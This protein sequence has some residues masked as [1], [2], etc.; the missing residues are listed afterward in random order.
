M[1]TGSLYGST[2]ESTGLYGIGAASGGTYFEWFIFYDS[3]TAPATPTGGSWSFTTNTGTAPT[4]WLTSP[5]ASPVNQVWVSLAIVD[6]RSTSSL[7]WTTPGLMSSF[8]NSVANYLTFVATSAPAYSAG[9]LWYDTNQKSF[10]YYNDVTNNVVHIGQETQLKV[11]NNTG[12]TITRGSPVYI[13]STS[14]GFNYP[15]VALAKADNQ[16]SGS[17]IGL[18]N[19]D[20]PT[21]TA[22]YITTAGLITGNTGA[23]TVGDTLYVSPYS[24]GQLMNTVPPTGYAVKIGIVA[25]SNTSNGTIYVSQTNAYVTAAQIVGTVSI[26]NGG[27]GATTAS[28]ARTALG[29][30]TIATQDASNV[31][32][33]GGSISL[34]TALPIA[35]GGT[36]ATTAAAART[37]LSVVGVT[38]TQ[39]L[40]NKTISGASNTLTN[41]GNASL[42]NSSV[43][44]NGSAIAL[45][46]SATITAAT[47]NNLV[48]G[49]QLSANASFNGSQQVNVNLL[50]VSNAGT[51]GTSNVV[52]VFTLNSYGQI[53]NVSPQT[54]TVDTTDISGTIGIGQGGTG[55]NNVTN[56]RVNLLPNYTGNAGKLLALNAGATDLEWKAV[57]G[58]GTVTSIDVSGGTTGLTTYGG[59]ITAAGTVTLAGTLNVANGG[60]GATTAAAA[61]TNLGATTVGGNLFTLTNPSAITFPQFNADNTVSA[62]TASAFRTAIGAGTSSATGTV[63]SVAATVPTFLSI[64]G[65]PITTSGTLAISLSGTALPTTSG[66]TG[67]T[68]F[69]ANGVVYA[70]STSALAT[71]S[72]LTYNGTVFGISYSDTAFAGGFVLK[73]TA[74]TGAAWARM[75]L[76]SGANSTFAIY[77]Q[78]DGTATLNATGANSITFSQNGSEGM[79]LTSTGLLINTTSN[80]NSAKLNVNGLAV[81]TDGT[82]SQYMGLCSGG[83]AFVGTLTNHPFAV[84]INGSEKAR[85]DTAG[86]LGLGVTPSAWSGYKVMQAG[87]ASF[88]GGSSGAY[89]IQ[90]NAYTDSAGA[91]WKYINSSYAAA[92]YY[93]ASGAHVW[94]TA[95]SGTA[96]NAITFTQAMTLDASGNLGLGTT[97]PNGYGSTY[98]VFTV[99]NATAGAVLDLNIAGTRTATLFTT[100]SETRLASVTNIPLTFYTNNTERARIDSSGNFG[101]GTSSPLCRATVAS[102][103]VAYSARGGIYVYTTDSMAVDLGGQI[104]FGGS[105]TGTSQTIFGSVAARK[106]NSTDSNTSAYLQFCTNNQSTGNAERARIDSSGNFG[107]GVIPAAKLDVNGTIYSRTGG[108]YT[109]SLTA[110]SGSSISINAGS[111]NFNVV[112]NGSE[113]ARIDSSGNLLVGTTSTTIPT[114]TNSLLWIASSG[115]LYGGHA[116]GTSSGAYYNAFAYNGSVIGSITQSGT[117]AVLFNV[118]SDQRLKENIVDAPEFGSV[119][120]SLQVRS[121]DWKTDHTH[122]RA[123]F[124]AQ[125]LVTVAPEA[126]HQ[127]ADPEEMMAVDYSKLVPMLV[128]EIQSLRKRLAAAGI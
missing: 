14:S 101:V 98:T 82:T 34:T 81:A 40:T 114:G 93:A 3:A 4:G 97:S 91:S 83:V 65:S 125:E 126:V 15:L 87:I 120:D 61:R 26:A 72:A 66:G 128:K 109:D 31:A 60:T 55:A 118:T 22:G 102:S 50:A 116:N 52:P 16:V 12:S 74:T 124:I 42:S 41:I 99:N 106:E 23:F 111:S 84:A 68:S 8:G 69:T 54:I 20:I 104:T 94:R 67:L 85:I 1:A 73:N 29:L 28:A 47:P 58:V 43:T 76:Q 90:D 119:I 56:A 64:S 10:A 30:G 113:R 39:T 100:S 103:N 62:L 86:N 46:S 9:R 11:Y 38:D 127:P 48:F 59:P 2:S 57:S 112:V 70:N 107:L 24:A 117:T 7:T 49:S 78:T 25:Y 89:L 123:G 80:P 96:G 19:Q 37:N 75:D 71:G 17:A 92:Q 108:I 77:Q 18:A 32:I 5:P 63:T 88:A 44:V 33:T 110:Y 21:A 36:G 51:Y 121:Y 6:S 45:G 27:T 79:R 95:P 13:T 122:Q 105:Y 35:S 115:A 53:T